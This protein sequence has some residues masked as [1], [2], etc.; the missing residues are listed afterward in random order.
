MGSKE[1]GFDVVYRGETRN[2]IYPGTHVFFQ[3][4]KE[5]GGGYW[6]GTVYDDFYKFIIERPVSIRE[7]IDYL[8]VMNKVVREGNVFDDSLDDFKLK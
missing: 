8:F 5:C 1:L 2:W 7:G 4:S 6:L 3:R